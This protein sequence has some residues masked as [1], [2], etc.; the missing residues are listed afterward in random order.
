MPGL[1][2]QGKRPRPRK[3]KLE[4]YRINK[5]LLFQIGEMEAVVTENGRDNV[6]ERT[7]RGGVD[8]S[9][10]VLETHPEPCPARPGTL[11]R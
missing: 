8:E 1:E 10:V 11:P 5:A 4:G 9:L 3:I 6:T 7:G 2:D